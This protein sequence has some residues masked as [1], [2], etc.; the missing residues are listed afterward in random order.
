MNLKRLVEYY[1][2]LVEALYKELSISSS[3]FHAGYVKGT[4]K[5]YKDVINDLKEILEKGEVK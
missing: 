5:S 4:V 2:M 3:D 1:E